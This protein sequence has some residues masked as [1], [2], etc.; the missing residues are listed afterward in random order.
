MKE[1]LQD[2]RIIEL[3][4]V[5]MVLEAVALVVWFKLKGS[6]I[7]PVELI[8]N[9]SAGMFLMLA[10][11]GA[12][13]NVPVWAIGGCLV[14]ALFAHLADLA[15]RWNESNSTAAPFGET[16]VTKHRLFERS[17]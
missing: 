17:L 12:L 6:G 5:L 2:G 8:V 15:L 10:V 14:A 16:V 7:A 4:L 11:L 1:M 9:I 3:I 13:E